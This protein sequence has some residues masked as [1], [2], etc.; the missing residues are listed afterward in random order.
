MRSRK[1]IRTALLIPLAAVIVI[2]AGF[3][4]TILAIQDGFIFRNVN[5]PESREFLRG[6]P[7]YSEIGFTA[8]NG[9]AYHGMLFRQAEGKAPLVIY[10]GGNGECSY[11][12]LRGRAN[13]DNWKYF[14][15]YNY[16]FA[17]YEGYGINGGRADYKKN[18]GQALAVYDYAVT[19]PF[20]D[21]SNIMVMGFSLGT[22]SAVYLAASRP[23][24]G[25][26]LAA[27]YAEGRDLYNNFL[28]LFY[29]PV[30]LLVKQ[31]L[32]SAGYAPNVKCP[33]LIFA[34]RTDEMVPFYSSRNLAKKFPG[35]A[36]FVE[37]DNTGHN[38]IFRAPGVLDRI[39]SFLL[40]SIQE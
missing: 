2:A 4:I 10:F 21:S 25:L 1:T 7:G 40:D 12:N 9:T 34:S 13:S 23:V 22:G 18:Y 16:L 17:D 37:L 39:H 14:E 29:G 5:D 15:G 24:S 19:L 36:D 20:V 28:P 26:V 30:R 32:N 11:S 6:K 31:K 3:C 38:G 35:N 8:K 27:P 33:V